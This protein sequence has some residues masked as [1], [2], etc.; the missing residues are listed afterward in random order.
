MESYHTDEGGA[1][2]K[3]TKMKINKNYKN[4]NRSQ[5]WSKVPR[6]RKKTQIGHN[7]E[8]KYKDEEKKHK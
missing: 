4:T 1:M 2:P 3:S 7:D 5:W 8:V 6:W